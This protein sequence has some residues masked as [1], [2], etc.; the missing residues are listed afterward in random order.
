MDLPSCCK[1]VIAYSVFQNG[2][3]EASR[4]KK[5]HWTIGAARQLREG[6][7]T[8]KK[9]TCSDEA[10][11]ACAMASQI[12]LLALTQCFQISARPTRAAGSGAAHRLDYPLASLCFVQ[13]RLFVETIG[14]SIAVW[15]CPFASKTVTCGFGNLFLISRAAF[16]AASYVPYPDFSCRSTAT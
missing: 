13:P 5:N 4:H 16:S 7:K 6:L 15:C 10:I 9:A 2:C 8:A 12:L 11:C 1:I 3:L 14:C